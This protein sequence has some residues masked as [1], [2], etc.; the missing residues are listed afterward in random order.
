MSSPIDQENF[1]HIKADAAAIQAKHAGNAGYRGHD[2]DA[3]LACTALSCLGI[4]SENHAER[5]TSA[6]RGDERVIMFGQDE[7]GDVNN[8]LAYV[9]AHT[10]SL[11][12][13]TPDLFGRFNYGS[14]S[15]IEHLKKGIAQLSDDD[16]DPGYDLAIVDGWQLPALKDDEI[17]P[18]PD[19]EIIL[20]DSSFTICSPAERIT[21]LLRV[22]RPSGKLIIAN[23]N[24][25]W[26]SDPE[27]FSRLQPADEV[28]QAI[29]RAGF[30]MAPVPAYS[31]PAATAQP[32][33]SK[34]PIPAS[35]R[36]LKLPYYILERPSEHREAT[37]VS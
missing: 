18:L 26:G 27:M 5:L 3:F 10:V 11:T 25:M 12:I 23:T 16:A 36:A 22:L 24:G 37:E 33:S 8:P 14:G 7:R 28:S 4:A 31:Y 17:C 19:E 15:D 29:E 34:Y 20:G 1:E 35:P 6:D 30:T 2:A 32:E 21:R 13:A 9:L